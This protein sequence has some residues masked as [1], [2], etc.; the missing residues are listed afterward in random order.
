MSDRNAKISWKGKTNVQNED[1][2]AKSAKD[3]KE[4]LLFEEES[5]AIQGSMFDVYREIGC[6]LTLK[7]MMR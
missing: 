1:L 3:A 6:G 5:Y 2:T 7:E 4:Y